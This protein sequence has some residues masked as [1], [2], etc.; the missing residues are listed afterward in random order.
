MGVQKARRPQSAGPQVN[1]INVS[2][3]S[4]TEETSETHVHY[5][6][7]NNIG[8]LYDDYVSGIEG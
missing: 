7:L 1:S 8:Y 6:S 4:D 2:S 3:C 5:H